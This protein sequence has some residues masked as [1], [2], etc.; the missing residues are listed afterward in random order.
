[1]TACTALEAG[2]S[3]ITNAQW[4]SI[5]QN[6]EMVGF[7]WNNGTVGDAGGM[8]TGHTDNSPPNASASSSDDNDSCAG[9][10][11]SCDLMTW[12]SQRR[13]FRLSN[14]SYIWD[15]GGNVWEWMADSNSSNF[16]VGAVTSTD[17]ADP[18][19]SFI[20]ILTNANHPAVL[21]VNTPLCLPEF[22]G[23]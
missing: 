21:P 1:M 8:S 22:M 23:Q 7:N 13:V 10:V 19:D 16:E 9:T 17:G 14:G 2:Y 15:F 12:N 3:L 11:Q 20:S 4:Q 6:L 18:A 5:A